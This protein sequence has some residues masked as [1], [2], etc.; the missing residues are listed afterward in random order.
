MAQ[1]GM[2]QEMFLTG[3]HSSY[4]MERPAEAKR[5]SLTDQFGGK[6]TKCG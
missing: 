2:M 6:S 1:V 3:M 5:S 4:R